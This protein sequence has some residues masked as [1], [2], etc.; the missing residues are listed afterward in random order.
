MSRCRARGEKGR[1]LRISWADRSTTENGG[2]QW[3][4]V[5]GTKRAGCSAY[6]P[7][8]TLFFRRLA[9][10]ASLSL[11]AACAGPTFI[12][13][14]YAGAAR[15]KETIATLR[16]NGA[17]AVRLATLDD[18]D[19]TAPLVEDG[20]LHLELLPGRHAIAVRNAKAPDERPTRLV[21]EAQAGKVYRV[22]FNPEARIFEVDRGTD[23]PGADVTASGE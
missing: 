21:F 23:A 14:Q 3:R 2:S 15:P 20:R 10:V 8:N 6:V 4:R 18:E 19:V 11:S 7:V 16:V 13:Q 12:V 9:L 17:N 5:L 22:A 1:F